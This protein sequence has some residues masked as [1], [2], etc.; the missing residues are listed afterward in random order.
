MLFEMGCFPKLDPVKAHGAN[1][2]PTPKYVR[3]TYYLP[4]LIT[5]NGVHILMKDPKLR[6]IH[7]WV[8]H[9]T[10]KIGCKYDGRHHWRNQEIPARLIYATTITLASKSGHG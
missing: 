1:A 5:R 10:S 3:L 2:A 9:S 6:Q 7:R 4:I 8:Y